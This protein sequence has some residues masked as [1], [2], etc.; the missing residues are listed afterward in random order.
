MKFFEH[1]SDTCWCCVSLRLRSSI[2]CT[3][4][5]KLRLGLFKASINVI[6]LIWSGIQYFREVDLTGLV[7]NIG[8]ACS[9][10]PVWCFF[11]P[12]Y[13]R[14]FKSISLLLIIGKRH[15]QGGWTQSGA[16]RVSS[17]VYANKLHLNF[18]KISF[19]VCWE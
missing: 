11:M 7:W 9:V 14:T 4:R 1:N 2:C 6:L 13:S 16:K 3:R 12:N 8:E 19:K 15:L 10:V 5:S 17:S 18:I